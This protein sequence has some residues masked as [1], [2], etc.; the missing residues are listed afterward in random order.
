MDKGLLKIQ[1]SYY[2][3]GQIMNHWPKYDR[4]NYHG[5]QQSWY[6]NGNKRDSHYCNMGTWIG[7]QQ[8][9]NEDGTRRFI[10]K[11]IN[12]NDNGPQIIFLYEN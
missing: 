10:K 2:D 8:N 7:I 4:S 9:W 5:L 6:E 1:I 11:Y 3:N 12:D